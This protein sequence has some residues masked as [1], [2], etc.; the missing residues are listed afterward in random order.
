MLPSLCSARPVLLEISKGCGGSLFWQPALTCVGMASLKD[1]RRRRRPG[2]S[3]VWAFPVALDGSRHMSSTHP[4]PCR[5][6]AVHSTW[7]RTLLRVDT[8]VSCH[9]LRC[10][11]R[12]TQIA[13]HPALS[14]H[15]GCSGPVTKEAPA[16]GEDR[17]RRGP[18]LARGLFSSKLSASTAPFSATLVLGL[19]DNLV[20]IDM[21]LGT[22]P[23]LCWLLC[24]SSTPSPSKHDDLPNREQTTTDKM[25]PIKGP[26]ER[27]QTGDRACYTR[28]PVILPGHHLTGSGR[29]GRIKSRAVCWSEK[30]QYRRSYLAH[31][32]C[33]MLAQSG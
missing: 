20:W 11:S 22:R 14:I 29:G 7:R 33:R 23:R 27:F 10:I 31:P 21:Y 1:T 16:Q 19:G 28:Y 8:A 15:Q 5:R 18:E 32:R 2:L 17:W 13:S 4:S 26:T 6:L 25:L 12:G 9:L 3:L 30:V 24:W